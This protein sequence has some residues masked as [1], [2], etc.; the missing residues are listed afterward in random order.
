MLPSPN[1]AWILEKLQGPPF[2]KAGHDWEKR[3]GRA[4]MGDEGSV[5]PLDWGLLTRRENQIVALVARG[6]TYPQV[7]ESLMISTRTVESHAAAIF[8]KLGVRSR[9]ELTVRALR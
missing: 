6:P 8:R 3:G 2:R 4:R 7:A 9:H 5:S 1:D